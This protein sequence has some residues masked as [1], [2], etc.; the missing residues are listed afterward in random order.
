MSDIKKIIVIFFMGFIFFSCNKT[1]YKTIKV[2]NKV[3]LKRYKLESLEDFKNWHFKDVLIDTLA[4]I[5]LNR[6]YDSL[7][8][9]RKPKK[10]IVAVIDMPIEINHLG[11][12]N[13]IWNN[14]NEISNNNFDDDQN[15]YMDDKNGWNFLSNKEGGTNYFVNYEYTRIIKEYSYKFKGKKIK[16]INQKD[17]TLF[18]VY[19]KAELKYKQRF[20]FANE[21]VEYIK[22]LSIWKKEAEE[23]ISKYIKNS[24]YGIHELDSLKN[25]YPKNKDLQDALIQKTNFIEWEFTDSYIKDYKLK[26]EERVSK[27]LNLDY[28]D[29]KIQGDNPKLINDIEYGT[30]KFEVNFEL[31]DHGTKMAGIIVNIGKNEELEIMSLAISAYGDEHDKDIALA[32]RYAVDNGAKVINMSFAKEFSLYPNWVLDA[33]KYAYEN[34]VLIVNGAGNDNQDLEIKNVTW[35]PN[36][37][38]H[39][40]KKEIS[41][42]FL[43]VGSSGLYINK[44][45]KSSF[46]NYGNNE[47]DIFAPGE[48]IYTTFPNNEYNLVYG[49]TSASSAIT[50]GVAALLYSYYPNLTA[51]QVKN[52]LMDSGLEYTIEVNTPTEEDKNKTI[53]FNILSKSGKVLNAYNALIMADSISRS[54]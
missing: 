39:E 4:G 11:L 5:S 19:K 47:V 32:I 26:A 33:I 50:S 27:L 12:K 20:M 36:D 21:E 3:S 13:Y 7:L 40:N 28:N 46:S 54:N 14:K 23:V 8:V 43:K 9:N 15:G 29:R 53:P 2:N 51:S 24:N 6:A 16:E 18:R 22:N 38:G 41:N 25:M 48:Y 35:F 42:N 17:S 30:P 1:N 44:K 37:H 49:G 31:L 45:L 52:I 34:N 10:I